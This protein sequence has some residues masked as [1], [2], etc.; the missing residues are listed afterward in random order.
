VV[1]FR[2][3]PNNFFRYILSFDTN[4]ASVS[5]FRK[6]FGVEIG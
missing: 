2:S 1:T 3:L 4:E 5:T 6:T